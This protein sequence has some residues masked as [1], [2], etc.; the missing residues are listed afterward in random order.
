M[1]FAPNLQVQTVNRAS[2]PRDVVALGA[3]EVLSAD[4]ELLVAVAGVA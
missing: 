2:Y 1:R 3:L 4:A